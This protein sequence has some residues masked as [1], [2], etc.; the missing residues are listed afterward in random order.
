MTNLTNETNNVAT[1]EMTLVDRLINAEV[2]LAQANAKLL[3]NETSKKDNYSDFYKALANAQLKFDTPKKSKSVKI[4][5]KSGNTINFAYAP[6]SEIIKATVPHLNAEGIYFSQRE[7][8]KSVQNG[9]FVSVRTVLSYGGEGEGL[10]IISDTMPLAYSVAD[11]KTARGVVT[12]LRR[13]GAIDI[14]GIDA[15]DDADAAVIPDNSY[16]QQNKQY[17]NYNQ[18]NQQRTS[19]NAN[20]Y[21]KNGQSTYPQSNKPAQPT[22]QT[23]PVQPVQPTAKPVQPVEN[24]QPVQTTTANVSQGGFTPKSNTTVK[25]TQSQEDIEKSF[26]SGLIKT[27]QFGAT[28]EDITKWENMEIKPA[29]IEMRNFVLAKMKE[30]ADNK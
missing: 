29:V 9:N 5:T 12:Y 30:L 6:L 15:E 16:N 24:E 19:N 23:Q 11:P 25:T 27:K 1:S 14:L 17:N 28:D 18:S 20:A 13:Y 22:A 10:E 21:P 8:I 7:I 3:D 2:A 4:P 26:K